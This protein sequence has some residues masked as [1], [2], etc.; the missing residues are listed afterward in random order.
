MAQPIAKQEDK[1]PMPGNTTYF[2]TVK[3]HGAPFV[4]ETPPEGS[5]NFTSGRK[6]AQTLASNIPDNTKTIDLRSCNSGTGGW[7][8]NAQML[9]NE[10]GRNVFGYAGRVGETHNDGE[11]RRFEPQSPT[12]AAFAG[13]V[14]NALGSI[15]AGGLHCCRRH[16]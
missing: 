5:G 8:S 11:R 1:Q 10:T 4:M 12:R 2:H 14:N 15:G 13:A 16:K 9:A 6:A 3:G 7:F